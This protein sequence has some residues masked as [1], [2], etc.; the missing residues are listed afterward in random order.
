MD[1]SFKVKPIQGEAEAG[2]AVSVRSAVSQPVGQAS[3][4]GLLF[5]FF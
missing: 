2:A 3:N 4:E 5:S 1:D